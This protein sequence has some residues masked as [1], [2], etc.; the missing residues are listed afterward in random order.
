MSDNQAI[1][2][3]KCQ[4]YMQNSSC[5]ACSTSAIDQVK[6]ISNANGISGPDNELQ[7]YKYACKIVFNEP[8]AIHDVD[9]VKCVY[10]LPNYLKIR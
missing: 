7:Y 6:K 8:E 9:P 1:Q 10:F 5:G 2:C 3:L 4:H